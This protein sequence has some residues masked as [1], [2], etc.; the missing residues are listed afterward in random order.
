MVEMA[1]LQ[2][3]CRL[4]CT[5]VQRAKTAGGCQ[6]PARLECWGADWVQQ[7]ENFSTAKSLG[8]HKPSP[9]PNTHSTA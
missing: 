3:R 2:R 5:S 6:R 1:I 4:V 8:S 7:G 9:S